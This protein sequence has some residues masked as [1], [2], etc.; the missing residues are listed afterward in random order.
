MWLFAPVEKTHSH[1]VAWDAELVGFDSK[2]GC[3]VDG[4]IPKTPPHRKFEAVF[5]PFWQSFYTCRL[6]LIDSSGN[7]IFGQFLATPPKNLLYY[8]YIYIYL[9]IWW[10]ETPRKLGVPLRPKNNF[11]HG[12]CSKSWHQKVQTSVKLIAKV[13]KNRHLFSPKKEATSVPKGH[14]FSGA[15]WLAGDCFREGELEQFARKT[16][17]PD[18][19][20]V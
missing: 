4:R 8:I 6:R 10:Q 2:R 3:L 14:H 7:N 19:A 18:C 9:Q 17:V 16:H 1:H 15:C 12:I 5:S 20:R 11:S 13:P